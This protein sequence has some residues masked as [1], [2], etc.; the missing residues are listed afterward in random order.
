MVDSILQPIDVVA[1]HVSLPVLD[2]ERAESFYL[3]L[4]GP[5]VTSREPG[6]TNLRFGGHRL[7]LREVTSDSESLQHG[8]RARLRARHWG[9]A[10]ASP[11]EVDAAAAVVERL[12][13]ATV[14]EPSDRSDGRTYLFCDESGNQVEI[15]YE[16]M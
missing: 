1:L 10:V 3:A 4:L 15:Y 6:L 9:F 12:G 14:V 8:G 11:G 7:A 16:R 13:G 2:L 5:T